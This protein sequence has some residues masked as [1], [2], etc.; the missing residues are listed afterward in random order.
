MDVKRMKNI[1]NKTAEFEDRNKRDS[2]KT[3]PSLSHFAQ[4]CQ[5]YYGLM[6]TFT[7]FYFVFV[8]NLHKKSAIE[9]LPPY[10]S[11]SSKMLVTE[12]YH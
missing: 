4:L 1:T 3:L 6:G 11:Q 9:M 8:L 10:S 12:C 2:W 7:F 5:P